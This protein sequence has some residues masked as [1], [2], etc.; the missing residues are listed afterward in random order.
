MLLRIDSSTHD[1]TSV[2]AVSGE[3]DIDTVDLLRDA[4]TD[5]LRAGVRDLTIDLNEVTYLDSSGLGVLVGT[6]K[7]LTASQGSLTVRCSA[8]RILRLFTITGLTD[9][10]RIDRTP[11]TNGVGVEDRA[12]Q[13]TV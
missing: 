11:P 12:R 13:V 4:V 10:L 1:D 9:L 7:R 3:I 6:Y 8:P 2:L 5:T